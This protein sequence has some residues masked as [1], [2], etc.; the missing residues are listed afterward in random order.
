MFGGQF[1]GHPWTADGT[2]AVKLDDPDHPLMAAFKG[3]NF[4]INDEIYRTIPPYYSRTTQR[5]LMSLDMSDKT[6][7]NAEEIEPSDKDMAISWVKSVGKGRLFYCSLGH[8]N[9]VTWNPAVLQHNLA[10]IQFALGDYPVDTTPSL[11]ILLNKIA[12]YEPDISQQPLYELDEYIRSAVYFEDELKRYEKHFISFLQSDATLNGK[13]HICR[14][15]AQI[16]TDESVPVLAEMLTKEDTSDMA[17]YALESIPSPAVDKALIDALEKTNG[18]TRISIINCLSQ[19]RTKDAVQDLK[20]LLTDSDTPTAAAAITALGQIATPQAALALEQHLD[21]TN[22]DLKPLILDSYLKCAYSTAKHGDNEQAFEMFKKSYQSQTSDA[23]RTASLRGMAQ[24]SPKKA[25]QIIIEAVKSNDLNIQTAA[26]QIVTENPQIKDIKPI[27]ER[28]PDLA[29]QQQIQLLGV[30]ANRS[31]TSMLDQVV[32]AAQSSEPSVR[33]A[34]YQTIAKI[35]DKSTVL[36]LAKVAAS[37][38]GPEQNAVRQSLYNMQ[39]NKVDNE[40]IK[41][42]PKVDAKIKAELIRTVAQRNIADG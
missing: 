3:E 9:S 33:I 8:N 16:G 14:K 4:K 25:N 26:I 31:E 35:G 29:P 27:I 42:I 38:R 34:A 23:V 24:S 13:F 15:L 22:A 12:K 19:R 1:C 41:Q 39:D 18:K 21:T 36:I 30:I 28:F 6:T 10:G 20:L 2:W 40:I 32:E 7:A 5:I 17:R 37:T 11:Q